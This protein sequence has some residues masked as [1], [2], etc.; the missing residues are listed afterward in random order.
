MMSMLAI[1]EMNQCIL[2]LAV[3]KPA[4]AENAVHRTTQTTSARIILAHEGH[5]GEVESDAKHGTGVWTGVH[6][7]G[8]RHH[9]HTDHTANRQVG[10]SLENQAGDAK[11]Q[12]SYGGRSLLENVQHVLSREQLRALNNRRNSAQGD[13]NQRKWRYTEAVVEQKQYAY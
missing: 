12:E 10:T 1:V 6:D 5:G 2:N 7:D 8:R 3:K 4:M 9:T 11:R 13:E